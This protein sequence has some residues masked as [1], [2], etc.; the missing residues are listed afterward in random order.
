MPRTGP[1]PHYGSKRRVHVSGY[2]DIFQPDH[3]LARS[4]GYVFEH[5]KIMWDA[6][7]LVDRDLQVHHVNGDKQDNRIANLQVLT[8]AEHSR[9]H[10]DELRPTHCPKGHEFT[11]E[12]TGRVP[13]GWRYCKQ[14][15]RDR[16]KRHRERAKAAA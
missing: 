14:C 9:L 3:P 10:W 5:R 11:P 1:R 12:N 16:V 6:G 2:I 7:R 15:N 8:A 13:E 4:D